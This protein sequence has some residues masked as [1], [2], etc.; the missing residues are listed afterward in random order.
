M[1]LLP[2]DDTRTRDA[3]DPRRLIEE[4]RQGFADLLAR[5]VLGDATR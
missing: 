2:L 3:L 1:A 5:T 4:I